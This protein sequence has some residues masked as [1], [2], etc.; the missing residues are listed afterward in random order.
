MGFLRHLAQ[1]LGDAVLAAASGP[2]YI[3]VTPED[4]EHLQACINWGEDYI[5]SPHAAL[6][7]KGDICPFVKAALRKN[8]MQFSL[9]SGL[10]R[11]DEQAIIRCLIEH[12]KILDELDDPED[13]DVHFNSYVLAFPNIKGD[14]MHVV[15]TVHTR[16]KSR[17]MR[18]G[19]MLAAFYPGY[20]KPGVYNKDFQLYQAPMPILVIRK[21]AIHDILF[22]D[23]NREGFAEYV[24]LFGA[25][26][27]AGKVS[28]EFGYPKRY[29]DAIERF[30]ID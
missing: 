4:F 6:G 25:R 28:D 12:G 18:R 22:L 14:D 8:R 26:Y 27:R 10:N 17:M 1:D 20:D 5:A 29:A 7:R 13:H 24:R 11:P 2:S 30:K 23:H 3:R 9:I 19:F 15:D 21:M 16:V